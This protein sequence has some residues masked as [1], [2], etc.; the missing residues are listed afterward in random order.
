LRSVCGGAKPEQS[1]SI[2]DTLSVATTIIPEQRR[3]ERQHEPV[4]QCRP[5]RSANSIVSAAATG[6]FRSH[7][8]GIR[9]QNRI[10]RNGRQES[11]QGQG[12]EHCRVRSGWQKGRRQNQGKRKQRLQCVSELRFDTESTKILASKNGITLRR[13]SCRLFYLYSLSCEAAG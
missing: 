11:R 8:E 9:R 4:W 12:Q 10:D 2:T 6:A 3:P 5:E 7:G 1:R 13:H